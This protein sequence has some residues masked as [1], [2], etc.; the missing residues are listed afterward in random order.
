[1]RRYLVLTTLTVALV[2]WGISYFLIIRPLIEMDNQLES[3]VVQV[4]ELVER[5]EA[6]ADH[7]DR[8]FGTPTPDI[9]EGMV[10]YLYTETGSQEEVPCNELFEYM[11]RYP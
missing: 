1:M 11:E 3:M 6:L 2:V 7:V 9:Y 4:D 10:C 8:V 5:A